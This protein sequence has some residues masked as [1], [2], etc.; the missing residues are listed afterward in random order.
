MLEYRFPE[1]EKDRAQQGLAILL[2]E[3]LTACLSDER[4]LEVDEDPGAASGMLLGLQGALTAAARHAQTWRKSQYDVLATEPPREDRMAQLRSLL[5]TLHLLLRD[6]SIPRYDETRLLRSLL[7]TVEVA[8]GERPRRA[9][10][11]EARGLP[12]RE[13]LKLAGEADKFEVGTGLR[14]AY[15]RFHVALGA[16]VNEMEGATGAPYRELLLEF[17]FADPELVEDLPEQVGKLLD[18]IEN[19]MKEGLVPLRCRDQFLQTVRAG[20]ISVYRAAERKSRKCSGIM[21]DPQADMLCAKAVAVGE[22]RR[23]LAGEA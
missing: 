20:V 11:A 4:A 18:V 3:G 8:Y 16:A 2:V 5:E 12:V 9:E 14:K 6:G 1:D 7:V 15:R 10:Y 22:L 23:E 13:L 21:A 19:L 17:A